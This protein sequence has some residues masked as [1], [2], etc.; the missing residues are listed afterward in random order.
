MTIK[1][2]LL[3]RLPIIKRF[4]RNA[5]APCHVTQGRGS[6]ITT[7]LES[8]TPYF[9]F[10]L[11]LSGAAVIMK[12]SLLMRLPVTKHFWRNTHAPCHVTGG[13]GGS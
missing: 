1:G 4:W 13:I 8:P 7:Y 5:H 9:L 3:M 11:Q 2:R 10:T 12:G 6:E